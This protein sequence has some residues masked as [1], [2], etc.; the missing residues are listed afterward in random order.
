MEA[1]TIKKLSSMLFYGFKAG[2]KTGLY[3][4][5]SRAQTMAAKF[6]I[7]PNLEKKIKEK[8]AKNKPLTKKEQEVVL[9]CSIE[10]PGSCQM[11]E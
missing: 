11:C 2:L 8:Q 6:T 1:P 9:A 5:R 10:N 3:Y 7:D 4:L